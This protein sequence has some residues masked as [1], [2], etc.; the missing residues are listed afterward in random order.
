MNDDPFVD[1]S[2]KPRVLFGAAVLSGS[3]QIAELAGRIGF[4][5]VWIDVEHGGATYSELEQLCMAIESG[6][7]IPTARLPN[8]HREHVLKALEAGARIV[9]VPMV[10]DA[11]TAR[12]I[13]RWGKFPPIGE[14]GF[15]SRS[16]GVGYGLTPA[17]EAFERANRSS[18]L[19]AQIE[20]RGA[21]RNLDRIC[22]VDGLAGIL[23]GPGDLSAAMGKT[24]NFDDPE[25]ITTV[26]NCI[27]HARSADK[28][29]GILVAPG[30][31]LDAAREAGADL[32]FCAGDINDLARAWRGVLA[33]VDGTRKP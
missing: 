12:E 15:N 1:E 23:I 6:G 21:V 24:A 17:V 19:F 30:P 14:R 5:S 31:L 32:I 27:R 28:H 16:R 33:A 4:D 11:E 13:I 29:A 25:L 10:N 20:T 26:A 3:M 18:H 8:H 2:G 9:V 22:G 7:A